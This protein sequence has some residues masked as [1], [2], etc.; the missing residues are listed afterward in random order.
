MLFT[1]FVVC[2]VWLCMWEIKFEFRFGFYIT[3]KLGQHL[4]ESEDL[5]E[6]TDAHQVSLFPPKWQSQIYFQ[7]LLVASSCYTMRVK[8]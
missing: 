4:E 7:G 2:Y 8:A 1:V 6:L 3:T 5:T